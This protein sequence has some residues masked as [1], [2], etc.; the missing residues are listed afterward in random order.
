MLSDPQAQEVRE[1]RDAAEPQ[2]GTKL[3]GRL[4]PFQDRDEQAVR[5]GDAARLTWVCPGRH[6]RWGRI[7]VLDEGHETSE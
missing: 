4:Q 5:E 7:C 6:G 1:W 2:L 3:C